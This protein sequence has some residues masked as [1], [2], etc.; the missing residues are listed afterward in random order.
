MSPEARRRVR[1]NTARVAAAIIVL[2][3][4]WT[5]PAYAA[6]SYVPVSG[7]GSTWSQNAIDQWAAN[8]QQYGI[9]V[10]YA[11]TGSSDGRRQ[12]K[13]G[14]VDLAVSEIPYGLTDA[15][16]HN[17][18]PPPARGYAYMPIVA[19]GTAF[20]YNLKIGGR[21]VTNL[22]LSGDTLVKIFTGVITQ[23]NDPAVKADN[24]GLALPA[25]KVV[26]VV[27]SD[28]SGTTAQLT[29]WM[30]T[31]H[32]AAWNSYCARLGI[33]T[34]CGQTSYYPVAGTEFIKAN[35]SNGV[36][37]YVKQDYAEGAITYV[38]YSYALNAR[39]PVAKVLNSSGY[40]IEPK[41]TGVAVGL[42]GAAINEDQ[43]SPSYLTQKLE[44]VYR[45]G[46]KRAYPLSSYSYMI[47]PT[48]LENGLTLNKAYT[49]SEFGY[50]FLCE[51]QQQADV[52]GYS[53]LPINLVRAGLDQIRKVRALSGADA[54][55]IDIAGCNNPTFS[56]D[57]TNT[58]AANAP[59]PPECDRKGATQCTTG[60]GGAE[61]PTP[62]SPGAQG[63]GPGGS[64]PG[65]ASNGLGLS[66]APGSG[67]GPGAGADWQDGEDLGVFGVPVS[68]D[69][70]GGWS[71]HHTAM[72]LAGIGLGALI[73][74]PPLLSR[75]RD[76]RKRSRA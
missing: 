1:L 8:V 63:N 43:G 3:L 17:A 12:F 54:K 47:I 30:K 9:V 65:G 21:R 5:S 36:A 13:E 41:A 55:N 20:M 68:L 27:R 6:P 33:S 31:E 73:F 72:L 76:R 7:A 71:P 52:L 4:W 59:Q 48:R 64:G 70:G 50:Y 16:D 37:G 67:N 57:G 34:P 32:Q 22:R 40:Y 42:L 26:P 58:L 75:L 28:G 11:G 49:V 10:N 39:F 53:P 19:G 24:P 14:T 66:G 44:G 61:A 46:D 2:A 74:T 60:T 56:K 25:R 23:W 62:V 38:E 15:V 29:T 45:N 69:G 51:G 35:G 18:D